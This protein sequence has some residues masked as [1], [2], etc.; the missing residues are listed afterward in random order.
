MGG[1]F[2]GGGKSLLHSDAS[3]VAE[4]DEMSDVW[5]GAG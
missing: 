4:S 2:S 1:R 5:G 3:N